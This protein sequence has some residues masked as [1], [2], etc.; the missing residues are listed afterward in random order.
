[1]STTSD[2]KTTAIISYIALIG[3]I[4]AVIMNSSNKNSFASY[5]IRNTIGLNLT[6]IVAVGLNKFLPGFIMWPLFVALFILWII[7]F[8][9]A[10]Q[11]EEKEIPIVGTF[12]QD[13]FRSI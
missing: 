2:G 13:W 7:G 12:F 6:W 9:G 11:E 8:I 1:M 10:I 5:H 3:L 4:I